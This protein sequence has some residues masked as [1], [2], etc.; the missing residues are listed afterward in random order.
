M[1]KIWSNK[2][3][4]AVP[5]SNTT[6]ENDKVLKELQRIVAELKVLEEKQLAMLAE[7]KELVEEDTLSGAQKKLKAL[8][9]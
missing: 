1:A 3:I 6:E 4:M 9:E 7:A 5:N 8:T 2:D